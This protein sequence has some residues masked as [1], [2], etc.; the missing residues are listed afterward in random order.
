[1][2]YRMTDTGTDAI[3]DDGSVTQLAIGTPEYEAFFE[4]LQAGGVMED[5]TTPP[6][7]SEPADPVEKLKSFL[8]DNP[9]V[10]ALLQPSS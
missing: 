10:A 3:A 8:T 5:A 9:D 2:K 7:A 4:W 1:M 6:M